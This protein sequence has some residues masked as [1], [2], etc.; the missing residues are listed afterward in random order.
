MLIT[1]NNVFWMER[2]YQPTQDIIEMLS[3]IRCNTNDE[4]V[5]FC[6]SAVES[7][8]VLTPILMTFDFKYQ[9]EADLIL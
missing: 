9:S 8:A 5:T 1:R 6:D 3:T 4:D 7:S 2:G